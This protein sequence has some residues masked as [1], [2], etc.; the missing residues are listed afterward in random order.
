MRE[1]STELD[2]LEEYEAFR[3]LMNEDPASEPAL[4]EDGYGRTTRRDEARRLE[5]PA[6]APS[7]PRHAQALAAALEA[8]IRLL[9]RQVADL[10][11]ERALRDEEPRAEEDEETAAP[12]PYLDWIDAHRD[13]LRAYPDEFVALDLEKGI[14]FHTADEQALAAWLEALPDEE[15]ERRMAF[16]TSMFV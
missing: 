12:T 9:E 14:V 13:E 4:P 5:R 2:E 8:R 11:A 6:N 1:S 15:R 10:R 3:S 16:H 7:A